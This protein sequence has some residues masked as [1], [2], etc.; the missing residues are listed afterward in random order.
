M[1]R[2]AAAPGSPR[3]GAGSA[4]GTGA[5]AAGSDPSQPPA[6]GPAC[7]GHPDRRGGRRARARGAAAVVP[8]PPRPGCAG[9]GRRDPRAVTSGR[10]G[11]RGRLRPVRAVPR[12]RRPLS[13]RP[14]TAPPGLPAGAQPSRWGQAPAARGPGASSRG[15]RGA[16]SAALLPRP[17]EG[18]PPPFAPLAPRSAQPVRRG[19]RDLSFRAP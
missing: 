11:R 7:R 3:W 9:G 13:A 6:R 1:V 18:R 10:K 2:A 17:A 8:C 15:A 16:A 5:L 14:R 4:A 12:P 19:K